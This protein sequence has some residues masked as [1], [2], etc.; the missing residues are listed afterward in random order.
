MIDNLD[1]DAANSIVDRALSYHRQGYFAEAED[2]Y[3]Q[4]LKIEPENCDVLDLLSC[5]Y[6][7]V[8]NHELALESIGQAIFID[9]SRANFYKTAGEVYFGLRNFPD[10]ADAF[11]QA[12]DLG[13]RSAENYEALINSLE[14]MEL[15]QEAAQVL[16][17]KY[18]LS[19][20]QLPYTRN[21]NA[22][23]KYSIGRY[24][25]GAPAIR[26]WHQGSTL[27]I[28]SFCSIAENVTILLGGNHP[29]EWVS[30]FPFS[31]VFDKFNDITYSHA[32]KGDV[33]I[34]N[35]VWIGINVTILSG[36]TIGD[37]AIIAAN[38]NVTKN[39]E[40]Y[41]IVGGNP[42][43]TIKKRFSDEAIAKLLVMEWWNWE[44]DKI[45]QNLDLILSDR[46]ESFIDRHTADNN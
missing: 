10:A 45:E 22:Y 23:K 40:P 8:G 42:A 43:K 30:S 33:I 38:A 14:A 6:L 36:V 18:S 28:G 24:T 29:T 13:D 5:L 4:V 37:G 31:V 27:K 3:L 26:D 2:L 25:Y 41:A 16:K 34:G 39:V 19:R 21:F 7:R 15:H 1:V 12:I 35:D 46:V 9:P 17:E 32:S 11:R 44:I 20:F